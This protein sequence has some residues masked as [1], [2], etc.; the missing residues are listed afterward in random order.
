M[1]G[2]R[3]ILNEK[4]AHGPDL[5]SSKGVKDNHDVNIG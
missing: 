2:E 5:T 4:L 1:A 3:I